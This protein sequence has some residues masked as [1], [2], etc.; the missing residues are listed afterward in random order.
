MIHMEAK[1]LEN[2]DKQDHI[3]KKATGNKAVSP[4]V[5]KTQALRK[6][7]RKV[8]RAQGKKIPVALKKGI[9][10]QLMQKKA[11]SLS[12]ADPLKKK[13]EKVLKDWP[14]AKNEAKDSEP[15]VK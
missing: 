3:T 5:V 8:L 6:K 4:R 10:H 2:A 15:T 1:K 14:Q 7:A 11:S 9:L 13:L 12:T